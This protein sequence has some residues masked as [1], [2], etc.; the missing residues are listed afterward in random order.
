MLAPPFCS[1]FG[2]EGSHPRAVTNIPAGDIAHL[3]NQWLIGG[4]APTAVQRSQWGRFCLACRV[5]CG[6]LGRAA[7][8]REWWAAEERQRIATA[9]ADGATSPVSGPEKIKVSTVA[10]KSNDLE[11]KSK[12]CRRRQSQTHTSDTRR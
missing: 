5:I 9:V 6:V 11:P 7:D 1:L 8:A 4:N 3:L 10:D 2:P 12:R